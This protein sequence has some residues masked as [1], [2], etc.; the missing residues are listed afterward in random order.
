MLLRPFSAIF[1]LFTLFTLCALLL[2]ACGGETAY[3]RKE[4]F[5]TDAGQHRDFTVAKAAL[6]E[7]TRR[8]LIGQGYLVV[9]Q[10]D[11]ND[12]I[13]VGQK[14][15]KQEKDRHAVL[16]LQVICSDQNGKGSLT[17]TALESHYDVAHTKEKTSFGLPLVAPVSII[18]SSTSEGQ[19]KRSG[20]TVTD[21]AFYDSLFRAVEKELGGR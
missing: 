21:R 17:A 8:V 1:T 15:F 4:R 10:D 20:E 12:Q 14:E 7:A 6:C 3:H 18:S 19:L 13:L 11:G 9:R 2:A 16:Q 5:S